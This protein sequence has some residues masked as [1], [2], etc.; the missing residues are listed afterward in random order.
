MR[1]EEYMKALG[2]VLFSTLSL[3]SGVAFSG[4][5]VSGKSC[6]SFSDSVLAHPRAAYIQ[7]RDPETLR[8]HRICDKDKAYS[9]N[10]PKYD[11]CQEW[12]TV[13]KQTNQNRAKGRCGGSKA[14]SQNPTKFDACVAET[15]L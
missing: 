7:M 15:A 8:I 4:E 13:S 11:T 6:G 10:K 3:G 2:I 5:V 1:T 9:D 14:L 12:Y